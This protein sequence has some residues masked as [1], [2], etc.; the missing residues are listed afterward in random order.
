MG[1]RIVILTGAREQ[2][3]LADFVAR[4]PD[5][6]GTVVTTQAA[7]AH[8]LAEDPAH[9]RLVAFL[10]SVIVPAAL[11]TGLGRTPTMCIRGRR[12]SLVFIRSAGPPTSA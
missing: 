2:Q 7:L 1:E 12:R 6:Q 11:L 8:A 3:P 9:T 4:L 10:T 5:I